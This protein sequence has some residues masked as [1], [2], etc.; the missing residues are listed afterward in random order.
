MKK[1]LV[2]LLALI[3]LLCSCQKD[4]E[5]EGDWHESYAAYCLLNLKDTVQYV[6]INRVFYSSDDPANYFQNPDSVNVDPDILRVTLVSQQEGVLEGD[7]IVFTPTDAF[8]KEEGLFSSEDY[9]VFKST[10]LLKADRTYQLIIRNIA[11]G[12]E[13]KAETGLLGNRPLSYSFAETRYYNI[14]Q[15]QP[16]VIDY[17]GSL[18]TSQFDKRI[19]RLLYY[20]Y[21]GDV[22]V[23]KYCDW[24][25][26]YTKSQEEGREDTAQLSDDLFRYFA[27]NIPVV[28]GVKRKAVGVD[29]MLVINDEMV[30]LFIGYSGNLSSGQYIPDFSNFDG[31]IG[32]FASRYYYTFFAM[33]LK[34]E[35]IDSLAYG[36]FTR[37]LG[38]ADSGGNWPPP[39]Q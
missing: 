37:D 3:L 21:E 22:K 7:S 1:F 2:L 13:M 15:Y 16:E 24:R 17:E 5:I 32:L 29:K 39:A 30:S 12:F 4:P 11:T 34:P 38:F 28:P 23:M 35:T 18:I 9:Y 27:E 10:D 19:I 14:N 25:S 20:E 31:G 6:R 26:P 8:P 36:R 33:G